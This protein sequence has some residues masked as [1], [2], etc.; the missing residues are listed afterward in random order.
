VKQFGGSSA[1]T[2][3][4]FNESIRNSA[5]ASAMKSI[6]Y[7]YDEIGN[8]YETSNVS[9]QAD[10]FYQPEGRLTVLGHDYILNNFS[11]NI[12]TQSP[13]W[14]FMQG[15]IS[16]GGFK[17]VA[18][19]NLG[20][21]DMDHH[22]LSTLSSLVNQNTGGRFVFAHILLPHDPYYFNADGSLATNTGTDSIGKS[23]KQKYLD[24]LQYVNGQMKTI[25]SNINAKS[26]GK[27]VVVLQSD[28]GPYPFQINDEDF[29]QN[30]VDEEVATGDMRA[31]K[32]RDLQMKYGNLA[33]YHL[34]GVDLAGDSSANAGATSANIF[35][36][37]MN[38]YFGAN[39]PYLPNCYY[40]YANGRS[41]PDVFVDI[42]KR[43]TGPA[44]EDSRCQA[45]GAVNP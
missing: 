19:T 29:D 1:Q 16:I 6:G 33:A 7:Q 41:E 3:V 17:V 36:L 31:W 21:V 5:V 18:Y 32:D 12:L 22:A 10:N 14:R 39:M 24:Q 45:N 15:G 11:K 2:V 8:W 30:N 27:A 25:L 43:L 23:V 42:T 9:A 20:D 34:P 28:E 37:V 26:G 13:L 44:T 4:P 35:R 38:S 40:A